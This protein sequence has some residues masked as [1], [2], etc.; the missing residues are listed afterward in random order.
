MHA[1]FADNAFEE[2][3][4]VSDQVVSTDSV[5]HPSNAISLA[6]LLASALREPE[7]AGLVRRRRSDAGAGATEG[8]G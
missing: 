6:P 8:P 1:V 7:A 4:R 3:A 5:P 2:L